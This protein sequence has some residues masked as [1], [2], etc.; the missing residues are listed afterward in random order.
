MSVSAGGSHTC[1]VRHSGQVSCW[2]WNHAGQLD[3]SAGTFRSVSAGSAHAC[4]VRTTGDCRLLGVD[5]IGPGRG[6]R[7]SVPLRECR[8]LRIP[9]GCEARG[10]C[11]LGQH[12]GRRDR[13]P[14]RTIRLG[15]H[16][17]RAHLRSAGVGGDCMLGRQLRRGDRCTSGCLCFLEYRLPLLLRAERGGRNGVLG[18]QLAFSFEATPLPG[19]HRSVSVGGTACLRLEQGWR[20]NVLGD[21]RLGGAAPTCQWTFPLAGTCRSARGL[22]TP[23][24]CES[25]VRS[26]AGEQETRAYRPAQ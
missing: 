23:V 6:P 11:V 25:L 21:G 24:H 2:G 1:G 12:R 4:G 26:S 15:N 8:V 10:H 5:R 13:G 16:W 20:S 19:L 22:L 14:A 3:T 9:V 18:V 17:F 7:G